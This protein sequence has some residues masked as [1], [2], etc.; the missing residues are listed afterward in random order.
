MSADAR[1]A[2][3]PRVV[4]AGGLAWPGV[5]PYVFYRTLTRV[6]SRGRHPGAGGCAG[7]GLAVHVA[8]GVA[9][10]AAGERDAVGDFLGKVC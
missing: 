7:S 8:S 1:A 4:G 5:L 6:V 10:E 9:G 3:R 2:A